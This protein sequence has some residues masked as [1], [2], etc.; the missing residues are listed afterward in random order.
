MADDLPADRA[1]V[2]AGGAG[3]AIA[4]AGEA[5]NRAAAEYLFAD[6]RQR[7]ARRTVTTQRA[8]LCLWVQY[9]VA[10]GAAGEL[11]A[12]GTAWARASF[13]ERMWAGL[14]EYAQAQRM[15]L[16]IIVGAHYC[17]SAPAAWRGVS[18]GLVEGFV[19]WMLNLGYSV[20]SVNNRLSAVKVYARLAA[21]AGVIPPTE[22]AL[23]REVRGYGNTEGKRVDAGRG[24]SRLGFK[25]EEAIVL[26]AA[27]AGQ[28]KSQHPPH[29]TGRTRPA[30]VL[31]VAG[32]GAAG[33]GSGGA[34]GGGFCGAG[35]CGGVP[36]EDG[37][38]RPDGAFSW[39]K[40]RVGGVP[41]IY[42][43][44]GAIVARQPEERQAD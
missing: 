17:Q 12:E 36:A 5:A 33:R 4:Q 30:V 26:T 44:A 9:L 28:L 22:L 25:K 2:A 34:D 16:P 13:D 14:D 42:A 15:E 41:A 38:H 18:W 6:Y 43:G 11:Q 20:S 37:Q 19:K 23:I 24:Q 35:L 7:R 1:L 21:K 32:F 31:P 10:I 8:G 27:Q 40:E 29:P 3:S 39:H